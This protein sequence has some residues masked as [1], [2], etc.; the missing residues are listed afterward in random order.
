MKRY[1][2]ILLLVAFSTMGFTCAQDVAETP[3]QKLYALK[4]DY[5]VALT[6]M[7]GYRVQCEA[8]AVELRRGCED[9]V[10][11]LQVIDNQ[12]FAGVAQAENAAKAGLS[13][14]LASANALLGTALAHL[15]AY[16]VENAI[17]GGPQ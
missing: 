7:V 10:R 9:H 17:S 5:R 6:A 16:I 4:S 13:V 1:I 12:V 2:T 14:E 15:N 11:K 8:K 3:L